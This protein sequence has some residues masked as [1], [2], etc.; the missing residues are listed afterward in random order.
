MILYRRLQAAAA[1]LV[2]AGGALACSEPSPPEQAVPG[3]PDR[4]TAYVAVRA[5]DASP[6]LRAPAR[7]V[8]SATSAADVSFLAMGGVT[9]VFVQVGDTVERG[10]TLFEV[11]SPELAQEA[12]EWRSTVDALEIAEERL[13]RLETLA[14][15]RI[16]SEDQLQARREEIVRLR[17]R[18]RQLQ[19]MLLAHG[20]ARGHFDA[21]HR[22]GRVR[23]ESPIDGLVRRVDVRLGQAIRA[24]GP[25]LA[26]IVG[27]GRPRVEATLADR[28]SPELTYAF[29]A[30]DGTRLPVRSHPIGSLVDPDTGT[31]TT[32]FEL[33]AAVA[34][35][36]ERVGELL[37]R[38]TGPDV[39]AVPAKALGRSDRGAYVVRAGEDELPE[40]VPVDVLYLDAHS[41]IVR[42]A[43][44]DSD[45]VALDPRAAS[46][47]EGA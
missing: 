27:T 46:K 47:G 15:E 37:G 41:A 23:I 8:A 6:V 38:A 4:A 21:V 9:G 33:P 43:L 16:A 45:R 35:Q 39:F 12:G 22:S 13:A 36:G 26:Q 32:W 24:D 1:A 18:Q 3:Q 17:G 11:A 44:S 29:V 31:W 28:P 42:G 2:L 30:S 5:G 14:A 7:L 34:L 20:V 19:G 10:A 40:R 25:P